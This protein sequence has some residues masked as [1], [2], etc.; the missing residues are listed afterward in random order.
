MEVNIDLKN[1]RFIFQLRTKVV[2]TLQ[3][4]YPEIISRFRNN[5]TFS[6]GSAFLNA[7]M[8]LFDWF[9]TA[10]VSSPK[11]DH[12]EAHHRRNRRAHR[13][14]QDCFGQSSDRHRRRPA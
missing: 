5:D 1:L 2:E 13:P 6:W 8:R 11:S 3:K 4:L 12:N 7:R 9:R 14:R 10:P